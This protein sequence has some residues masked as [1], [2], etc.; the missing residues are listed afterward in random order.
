MVYSNSHL[1]EWSAERS[2]SPDSQALGHL[3]DRKLRHLLLPPDPAL[4]S[5]DMKS[6]DAQPGHAVMAWTKLV[7]PVMP[8]LSVSDMSVLMTVWLCS[9]I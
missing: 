6:F 8:N 7:R 5:D 3:T 4:H 1:A 9:A 2:A